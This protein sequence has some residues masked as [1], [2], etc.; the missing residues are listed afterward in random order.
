MFFIGINAALFALTLAGF[1]AFNPAQAQQETLQ[2]VIAV[3]YGDH[4][5]NPVILFTLT[6]S[7]G[8]RLVLDVPPHVMGAAGGITALMGVRAEV[9]VAG[10]QMAFRRMSRAR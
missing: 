3:T 2:G 10:G 4:P 5:E 8:R 6:T 7:D 1:G 9:S